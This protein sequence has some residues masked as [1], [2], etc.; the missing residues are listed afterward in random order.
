[1]NNPGIFVSVDTLLL[2]KPDYLLNRSIF[3]ALGERRFLHITFPTL[4]TNQIKYLHN[5]RKWVNIWN[6]V[7]WY[8]SDVFSQLSTNQPMLLRQLS[9]GIYL[10]RNIGSI[11]L[12][13]NDI[14]VLFPQSNRELLTRSV[15]DL[16]SM[17]A[18]AQS[19]FRATS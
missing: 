9:L 8:R 17:T 4:N 19:I 12:S 3:W 15:L 7:F 18:T 10:H 2:R 5:M 6:I 1:M 14:S 16:Q 13:G 11:S